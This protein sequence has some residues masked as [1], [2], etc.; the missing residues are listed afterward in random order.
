MQEVFIVGAKRTA[1]GSFNGTLAG[2]P[3]PQLGATAIKAAL[4]QSGIN[5]AEDLQ[6]RLMMQ[7]NPRL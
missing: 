2:T 7:M 3:A 6:R 4:E 1:M 5:P